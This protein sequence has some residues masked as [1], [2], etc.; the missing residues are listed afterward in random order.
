MLKLDSSNFCL[1]LGLLTILTLAFSSALSVNIPVPINYS[2]IP[3]VNNTEHFGGYTVAG[4]YNY[5]LGF[6]DGEFYPL[7]NPNNF[8]N[9]SGETDPKAYNGTLALNDS[10][11]SFIING[12][13]INVKTINATNITAYNLLINDPTYGEVLASSVVLTYGSNF[14]TVNNSEDIVPIPVRVGINQVEDYYI[15]F[16]SGALNGLNYLIND[17]VENFSIFNIRTGWAY[18]NDTLYTLNDLAGISVGDT[19]EIRIANS[20][21]IYGDGNVDIRANGTF[22]G[23]LNVEGDVYANSFDSDVSKSKGSVLW[24]N[25]N[26]TVYSTG[27]MIAYWK[28]DGDA[29]DSFYNN[30]D[31]TGFPAVGSLK[32]EG[33]ALFTGTGKISIP[34]AP[35]LDL[36]NGFTIQF[37]FQKGVA[38]YQN[39]SLVK[40]GNY[41]IKWVDKGDG[42]NGAVWATVGGVTLKSSYADPEDVDS[43]VTLVWNK[44]EGDV[45]LYINGQLVNSSLNT[46]YSLND[47]NDSLEFGEN[48]EGLM[49]EVAF[50]DYDIEATNVKKQ[51]TKSYNL[52]HYCSPDELFYR[53][54][55]SPFDNYLTQNF[56]ISTLYQADNVK[57]ILGTGADFSIYY[58]GTN[59][60]INPK[61]V[62]SGI[63]KILGAVNT[64]GNI[65]PQT[66]NLYSLGNASARW[67]K[68]WSNG[69]DVNGTT[70]TVNLNITNLT[71]LNNA[72]IMGNLSVKRPYLS[73]YDNSTQSF[74][75]TSQVQI[76]NISTITDNWLVTIVNKTNI[77][78]SK[79]GDYHIS[80]SPAFYQAS[81][82]NKEIMFW[83]RK[84]GVDINW[85]NSPY[86]MIN[87]ARVTP[88]I[89]FNVDI[90]N[91]LTDSIQL[92]W[93]SDSTDS[94][95]ATMVGLTSPSRPASPSILME[96]SENSALT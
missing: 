2:Q 44:L 12:T 24:A 38:K 91:P 90:E 55:I 14:I 58:D 52:N 39:G 40:K 78:F 48:F 26:P 18:Y 57:H 19:F 95:L 72:N 28:M 88:E 20:G 49:E 42:V 87:G 96:V 66:N 45:Y 83:I 93:W 62:G 67:L 53:N 82:M 22:G 36:V 46:V 10:L 64:T 68:I 32:I 60:V 94:Q 17:S 75:N 59:A 61:E 43:F 27:S 30:Y 69:L 16:T 65:L 33:A 25:C 76:M 50:Y 74:L 79:T 6:L 77:T 84:N 81:G 11:S 8:I 29:T 56:N 80:V 3:T 86:T 34:D 63:L 4:L 51:Y 13:D 71:T 9:N 1:A 31:G 70:T 92:M 85:T 15:L 54:S 89:T 7:S 23:N 73:A 47:S 35:A 21:N 5:F 37:W 41:E